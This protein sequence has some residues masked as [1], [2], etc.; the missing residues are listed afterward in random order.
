MTSSMCRRGTGRISSSSFS[1]GISASGDTSIKGTSLG[2]SNV[3]VTV[4]REGRRSLLRDGGGLATGIGRRTTEGS[5]EANQALLSMWLLLLVCAEL[6][7]LYWWCTNYVV[8]LFL[9]CY[10]LWYMDG[11]EHRGTRRWNAF[12]R[13]RIWKWLSPVEYVM[14]SP[15][16]Q[17]DPSPR[18]YVALPGDTH[19]PLIW[20]FG[21]H[22]GALSEAMSERLLYVVPPVYMWVPLLR[23]VLL[24]SGAICTGKKTSLNV[25]LQ[26]AIVKETS[27]VAFYA[28]H[29]SNTYMPPRDGAGEVRTQAVSDEMLSFVLERTMSMG[30]VVIAKEHE[31]YWIMSSNVCRVHTLQRACWER[32]RHAFPLVCCYRGYFSRRPPPKVLLQ[33]GPMQHYTKTLFPTAASLKED[34]ETTVDA[35]CVRDLHDDVL[36]MN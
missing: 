8:A 20:G 12:R 29:T 24:W 4:D 17:S 15:D 6:V 19:V 32:T 14:A 11:S 27:S 23:D 2:A 3:T 36:K 33:F 5:H 1:F 21:L 34:F 30:V 13:L 7:A 18:L 35:L 28:S 26:D 22:G 10:A 9:L 25:L 16:F 31:R